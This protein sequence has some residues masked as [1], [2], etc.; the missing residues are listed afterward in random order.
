MR[1]HADRIQLRHQIFGNAV[2]EDALALDGRL[3]GGV[4]GGGVVLE[5]LNER[6][7]L[8]PLVEDFGLAF[9]DHS[10]AFHGGMSYANAAG[11]AAQNARREP[12]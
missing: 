1:R 5:I 12:A 6:A 3:L 11:A 9:V 2:V 8:G 4:E 7:R 10:A